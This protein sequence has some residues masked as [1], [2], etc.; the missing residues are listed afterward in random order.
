M[1]H[2]ASRGLFKYVNNFRHYLPGVLDQIMRS[3]GHG[4]RVVVGG[5][6]LEMGH[7]F[8]PCAHLKQLNIQFAGVHSGNPV[9]SHVI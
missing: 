3:V 2:R 1:N 5:W 7:V 6:C 8:T 4:A 9:C